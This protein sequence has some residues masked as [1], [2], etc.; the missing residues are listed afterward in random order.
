M[1][2]LL[3]KMAFLPIAGTS[4]RDVIFARS[5]GTVKDNALGDWQ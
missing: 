4:R 3:P 5:L 1:A 2:I